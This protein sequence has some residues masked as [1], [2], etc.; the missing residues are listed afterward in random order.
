MTPAVCRPRHRIGW[1]GSGLPRLQFECAEMLF[2][3]GHELGPAV[4]MTVPPEMLE[5]VCGRDTAEPRAGKKFRPARQPLHE[6]AAI[7]ISDSRGVRFALRSN[8]GHIER[9][10]VGHHC[11]PFFAS[12]DD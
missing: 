11:R 7:R 8:R 4:R 10:A 2:V 9:T 6:S 5:G 12:R 1:V 3:T